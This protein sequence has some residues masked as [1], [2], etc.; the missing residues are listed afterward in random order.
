[1]PSAFLI[2]SAIILVG[3]LIILVAVWLTSEPEDRAPL[4]ATPPESL[5]PAD[6]NPL[7]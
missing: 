1:M 3:A 7:D 2:T 5:E 6:E 4:P